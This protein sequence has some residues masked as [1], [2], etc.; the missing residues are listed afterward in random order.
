MANSVRSL[1]TLLVENPVHSSGMWAKK[2]YSHLDRAVVCQLLNM[3]EKKT[4]C[5]MDRVEASQPLDMKA[6]MACS[7]LDKAE[8]VEV[9]QPP[10][11]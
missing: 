2:A 7:H 4:C 1:G 9:S 8:E 11:M 10:E 6:K 5:R 3:R